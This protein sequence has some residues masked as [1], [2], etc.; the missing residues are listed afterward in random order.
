MPRN[1]AV[2]GGAPLITGRAAAFSVCYIRV[3]F[4]HFVLIVNK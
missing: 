4:L 2:R 3:E 1:A